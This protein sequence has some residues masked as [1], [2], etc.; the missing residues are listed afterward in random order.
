MDHKQLP[1]SVLSGFLGAG[2]TTLLNH[3]LNNRQGLRVAVI[4]NDMSEINI[5][6]Q[7]VRE[8]GAALSRT[9]EKLIELTNGCICCTLRDDLLAEVSRLAREDRFDYLLIE[10]TG[11]AEPLPIAITFTFEDETG[12]SLA[13]VAR[14]DTLVTVVD[15]LNFW[16]DFDS[17][18]EL[19]ERGLGMNE[20]DERTLVD[21]LVD[22]V[23]FANVIVINKVDLVDEADL[24]RLEAVLRHLNP[25][26][27]L[28]RSEY[29]RIALEQ[30]LNTGLFKLDETA[31]TPG[32]IK[33]LNNEHIP[34]TEEYGIGSFVYRA[35]RPFHPERLWNFIQAEEMEQVIRSK[36]LTWLASRPDFVAVWSHAGSV[37]SLEIGG[38][39]W[40]LEAMTTD[41]E[42]GLA[43]SGEFNQAEI[44]QQRQELVF[45]G[46]AIE[47]S[48]L[49]AA[50]NACL[51][52]D[53]ELAWG[54]SI[55]T[56]WPDPFPEW[57]LAVFD[58]SDVLLEAAVIDPL[59]PR[60]NGKP[61]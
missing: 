11:I 43:L 27:R 22:Q 55:W 6:A 13:E 38:R 33:E 35:E 44:C 24:G 21:L 50:L 51:L 45:I 32:W 26:A 34:E 61:T 60:L 3:I 18:E 15:A 39:W 14:L 48:R 54:P 19:W 23:E 56:T 37:F 40:P 25:E 52:T 47:R 49:E 41:Q 59:L 42:S 17:T 36:G 16:Q 30:V 58:E 20:T 46:I 57:D 4:V 5:D 31:L 8:G 9:E 7:L 29:G 10:A 12:R 1:V 53:A 2:K 28:L